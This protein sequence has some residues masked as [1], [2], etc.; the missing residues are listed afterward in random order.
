MLTQWGRRLSPG[1]TEGADCAL[2]RRAVDAKAKFDAVVIESAT[3]LVRVVFLL[4]ILLLATLAVTLGVGAI[5]IVRRMWMVDA[6]ALIEV[7]ADIAFGLLLATVIG[8]ARKVR[9]R[10]R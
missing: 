4:A 6:T 2:Q 8:I 9:P 5:A 10:R 1:G 3:T 7:E